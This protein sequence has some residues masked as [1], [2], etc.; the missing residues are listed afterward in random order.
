MK[1]LTDLFSS[2]SETV[3]VP[4]YV[5]ERSKEETRAMQDRTAQLIQDGV[6]D[7]FADQAKR[8]LMEQWANAEND[9]ARRELYHELAGLRRLVGK[10]K[11]NKDK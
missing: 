9:E 11:S 2:K 10:I 6:V 3:F 8:T 1:T 7:F 5:E 4:V